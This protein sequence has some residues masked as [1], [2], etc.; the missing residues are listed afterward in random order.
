M[1]DKV[2]SLP[3]PLISVPFITNMS[4]CLG[5]DAETRAIHINVTVKNYPSMTQH[6]LSKKYPGLVIYSTL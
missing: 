5:S 1:P 3:I 6:V 4:S 2:L